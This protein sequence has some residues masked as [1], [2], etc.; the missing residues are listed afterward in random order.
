[1]I[2][3]IR[4]EKGQSIIEFVLMLAIVVVITAILRN[5]FIKTFQLTWIRLASVIKTYA[6]NADSEL[7]SKSSQIIQ[8]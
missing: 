3:N 8:F 6:C 1:M 7:L 2:L 4:K 5:G